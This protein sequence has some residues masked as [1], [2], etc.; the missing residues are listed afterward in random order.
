MEILGRANVYASLLQSDNVRLIMEI[1]VLFALNERILRNIEPLFLR[2]N[3]LED[4]EAAF[5]NALQMIVDEGYNLEEAR[6][7]PNYGKLL[8]ELISIENRKKKL[9]NRFNALIKALS[10]FNDGI[11]EDI[12]KQN[13]S[14][15]EDDDWNLNEYKRNA[16]KKY[17]EANYIKKKQVFLS[18]A[19]EDK[20]YTIALFFSFKNTIFIYS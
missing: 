14:I 16:Y 19:Y 5:F 13:K 3:V 8:S 15:F 9:P 1:K 6:N 11:I 2:E 10:D 7:I 20:L 4:R 12:V 17:L 18:Y